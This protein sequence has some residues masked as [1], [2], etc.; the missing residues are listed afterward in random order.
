MWRIFA[1]QERITLAPE[2]ADYNFRVYRLSLLQFSVWI[3]CKNKVSFAAFREVRKYELL[4]AFY[5][6]RKQQCKVINWVLQRGPV[7]GSVQGLSRQSNLGPQLVCWC[8]RV[9]V[10]CGVTLLTNKGFWFL[11]PWIIQSSASVC[12]TSPKQPYPFIASPCVCPRPKCPDL[13]QRTNKMF[14]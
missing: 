7:L 10:Y 3:P 12:Y 6:R 1:T 8:R 13:F 9:S 2:R 11:N 5:I 14:G 4:L